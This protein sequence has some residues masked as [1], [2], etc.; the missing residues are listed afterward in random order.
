LNT[1]T[2]TQKRHTITKSRSD[3]VSNYYI[4]RTH[5]EFKNLFGIQED[6]Q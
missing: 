1:P 3:L 4:E 5:L 2:E 6:I